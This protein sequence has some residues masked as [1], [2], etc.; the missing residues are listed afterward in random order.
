[1]EDTDIV[2]LYLERNEHAISESNNKY[3]RYCYSISYSILCDSGESEE[4]VSDTWLAAWNRIPPEVPCVLKA[5]LGRITRNISVKRLREKRAEK[6]GG[7]EY[8]LALD[9]LSE[10]I[11][12]SSD[13]ESE[14]ERGELTR[15]IDNFLREC[16]KDQRRIF[17]L[18]Y[19]Y[20]Y[21]VSQ[22]SS[23]L[24]YSESKVK[25]SLLRTRQG[26]LERLEKEGFS[27]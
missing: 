12:D 26:L 5:Y 9:E 7:G 8:P 4:C 3:G 22:I 17:V 23:M 24:G 20:L 21:S 18:R 11:P 6:R 10:C 25:M 13:V 2:R 27:K 16:K 19:W 14:L 15:V 1:M